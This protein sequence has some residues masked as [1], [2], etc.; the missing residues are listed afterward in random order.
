[1]WNQVFQQQSSVSHD[2]RDLEQTL[3]VFYFS[4]PNE[5][6]INLTSSSWLIFWAEHHRAI[7]SSHLEKTFKITK[8][9][10]HQPDLL[11]P[12]TK[13]RLSVSDGNVSLPCTHLFVMCRGHLSFKEEVY[14][15]HLHS[16]QERLQ[17]R[18]F[19]QVSHSP[20]LAV[21]RAST[22]SIQTAF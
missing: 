17:K 2:L 20:Q 14:W 16:Q 7:E 5:I 1:M 3:A 8:T 10:N 19:I 18:L 22:W 6:L 11:S 15:K 4:K 13:Q 12:T 9:N 21:V